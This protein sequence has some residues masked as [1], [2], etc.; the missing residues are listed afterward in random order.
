MKIVLAPDSFKGSLAA[1]GVARALAD[2]IRRVWPNVRCVELPVADGGEGT[3]DALAAATEGRLFA[4]TVTGPIGEPTEARWALLGPGG[5]T[6][7]VEL[8]EAAGLTKLPPERRDPKVTTT[9]GVG[10]LLL[11]AARYPGV[12]RVL[13][14]LGGS[15]TNDGGAGLLQ[16]LGVRLLD[17]AGRDLPPGGAALADLASANTDELRLDPAAT[18]IVIAC[19]VDNPLTGPRGASAVF[20]PQKGATPDDVALLDTALARYG[21]VLASAGRPVADLPGAGAAGGTAAALLW[22]FPNALLRPGIEIVL[23]ALRFEEHLRDADLVLTGEGRLDAQ[24]LGG[25]AVAGVARR[26]R[27]AGVP[28]AALVGLLAD[29]IDAD[30]LGALGIAAVL[31]VVP[32]PC[33][34]A[35]AMARAPEWIGAAAE[36]AARWLSLGSLL[37]P[38]G[39]SPS[40][41][42]V[43]DR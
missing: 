42:A 33:A 11:E 22:L 17:S 20:G 16:A 35:E 15:A 7:V 43:T 24:T 1:P 25:K 8:A 14:A 29:D 18:D 41:A 3:A 12:R 32:G 30:A 6:A 26:A 5:E 37:P 36:R 27:A 34:A 2:G 39:G 19:D 40:S 28:V 23:D 10:E 31:P 21:G 4:A 38:V 13:V 9:R